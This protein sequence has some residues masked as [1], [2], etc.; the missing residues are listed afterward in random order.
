MLAQK[1]GAAGS[2]LSG[3]WERTRISQTAKPPA[4]PIQSRRWRARVSMIA[5]RKIPM[6][7]TR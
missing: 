7:L 1:K 6:L 4:T 2:K 5:A 3:C